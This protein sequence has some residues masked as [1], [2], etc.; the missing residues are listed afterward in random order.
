MY[1]DYDRGEIRRVHYYGNTPPVASFTATPAIGPAP[2]DVTFDASASSDVRGDPLTYAWDLDGDGQYDDATGVTASRTY[3]DLGNVTVGLKVTDLDDISDTDSKVDLGGQRAADGHHRY[4]GPIADL[5]GRRH[6]PLQ[7]DGLRRAGRHV[8]AV[9]VHVDPDDAALPIRLPLARHRDVQRRHVRLVRRTRSRG[10]VASPAVGRGDRFERLDGDRF[11][12][13]LP[14]DGYRV[15]HDLAAAAS[16][17]RPA[18]PPAVAPVATAIVGSTVHV[19]APSTRDRRRRALDASR[20]GRMA[21]LRTHSIPVVA[22]D[23]PLTATYTFTASVDRPEH[24]CGRGHRV[25]P[26]RRR[27]DP[28]PSGRAS[29]ID[30]YRFKLTKTTQTRLALGGLTTGGR[31]ELYQGCSKLLQTSDRA[32]NGSEEIIRS[33]PAGTY[34]VR[35]VGSATPETAN[36]ALIIKPLGATVGVLTYRARRS[37][38]RPFA[39]S[40]RS[41]TTRGPSAVR[42]PSRPGCTTSMASSSR[43][44]ARRSCCPTCPPTPERR[45]RSSGS[46]PAGYDHVAWSVSAPT[47]SQSRWSPRRRRS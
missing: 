26:D 34:G 12:R 16:R 27:S 19:T 18:R 35:L 42:S 6:H 36:H 41:T 5:A 17:R 9:R 11:D 31:M 1:A 20:A 2:L 37:R 44:A 47:T 32:G 25:R 13:P 28:A 43:R 33:L 3:T 8:A 4:T 24:V 21:A 14:A 39:S 10:A 30:W 15:G 7:R 38:D 45:S 22:G 23:Q 29:D 46:K 40:A